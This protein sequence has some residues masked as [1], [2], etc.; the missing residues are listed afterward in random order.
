MATWPGMPCALPRRCINRKADAERPDHVE[1]IARFEGR[2][3]VGAAADAFVEKLDPA[4]L[5][6]DPIDALWAAQP[7]L[8]GIRRGAEQI[9]E[10][11]GLDRERLGRGI[12]DQMLVFGI[13]PLVRDHRA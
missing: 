7:Q 5:P 2:Q 10:L 8:P 1:L 11:T 3:S 12:H 4:V 9:E 6:I 13:H